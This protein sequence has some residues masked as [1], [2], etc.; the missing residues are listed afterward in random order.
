MKTISLFFIAMLT[1]AISL[2]QMKYQ[3][4]V[5]VVVLGPHNPT[6]N[7]SDFPDL[8]FYYTPNLVFKKSGASKNVNKNAW[9]SALGLGRTAVAEAYDSYTGEPDVIVQKK[10]HSGTVYLLDKNAVIAGKKK[11]ATDF[12]SRNPMLI[13]TDFKK[14]QRKPVFEKFD[15]LLKS[16]VKKGETVQKGKSKFEDVGT[17]FYNFKVS[18]V[19]GA[20]HDMSSLIDGNQ[21]T[22]V[23]FVYINPEYDFQKARESGKGKKGKTY[24][25]QVAQSVAA[26]KQMKP[27]YAMEETVFGN[28]IKR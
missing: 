16:L 6:M 17:D 23:F 14:L 9:S 19:N 24:M 22:L 8:N 3:P 21:A 18:D 26:E 7:E 11:N 1:A 10:I 27:L 28:R 5:V 20:E 4:K 2:G 25:N 12:F 15:D 13:V